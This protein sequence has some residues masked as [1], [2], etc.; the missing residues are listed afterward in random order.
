MVFDNQRIMHG[1]LGFDS[2]EE[3]MLEGWYSEWD[4]LLSYLRIAKIKKLRTNNS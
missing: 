1:R 3:R 4:T 2:S